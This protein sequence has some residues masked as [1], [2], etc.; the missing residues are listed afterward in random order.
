MTVEILE[1]APTTM[2]IARDNIVSGRVVFDT[3]ECP[4]PF[5][6]VMAYDQAAGR[7]QRGRS[8][9]AKRG[10][11]LCATYYF[12]HGLAS[13]ERAALLALLT[14]VAVAEA[15]NT[16][17][18]PAWKH[19]S[20]LPRSAV[21]LKWPNDVL[22]HQKK[23]GGILVELIRA[24][25]GHWTALIG[26]G[27]N[28]AVRTF[29]EDLTNSATSLLPYPAAPDQIESLANA[30]AGS[31]HHWAAIARRDGFRAVLDA[32]R[33][34]DRTPG[35]HFETELD[36]TSVWGE[37]QGVD[38]EGAL[39]L[40]LNSGRQIAVTSASCLVNFVQPD[41]SWSNASPRE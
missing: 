25:D 8:W 16:I 22:L 36:G 23:V 34:L 38:D 17:D 11:S 1:S 6:G 10:D 14:G 4:S 3:D 24:R 35:M 40:R 41:V 2:E 27:I 33:S 30:I 28:V 5:A 15:I 31:L 18:I 26:V 32:W 21:G 9:F 12:R 13:P 19:A 7:G 39:L 37:A 20:K 29:P